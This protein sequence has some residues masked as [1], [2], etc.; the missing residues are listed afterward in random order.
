MNQHEGLQQL[1]CNAGM[2]LLTTSKGKSAPGT[3]PVCNE[4]IE[5]DIH[6][7]MGGHI[8]RAARQVPEVVVNPSAVL[9]HA[10]SAVVVVQLNVLPH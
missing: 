2:K 10:V 1:V 4:K 3:C 8:L 5:S 6:S 7:H 9:S